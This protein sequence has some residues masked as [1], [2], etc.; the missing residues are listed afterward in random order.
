M[1]GSPSPPCRSGP[2]GPPVDI[3]FRDWW[4]LPKPRGPGRC[5]SGRSVSTEAKGAVSLRTASRAG[6]RRGRAGTGLPRRTGPCRPTGMATWAAQQGLGPPPDT[7]LPSGGRLLR[8]K[9]QC[10]LCLEGR[11]VKPRLKPASQPPGQGLPSVRTPPPGPVS[12]EPGPQ[13]AVVGSAPRQED[14]RV[15]ATPSHDP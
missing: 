5:G 13:E 2:A 6:Q 7:G 1:V 15:P 11:R 12:G 3:T 14:P 8:A 9:G 10:R 4:D